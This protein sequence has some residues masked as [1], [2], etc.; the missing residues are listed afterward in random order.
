MPCNS[1]TSAYDELHADMTVLINFPVSLRT[2]REKYRTD[3]QTV[4]SS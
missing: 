4:I 2:Y 1:L 3:L